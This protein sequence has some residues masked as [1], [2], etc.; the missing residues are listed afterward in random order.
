MIK[1]TALYPNADGVEF[2]YDYYVNKHIPLVNELLSP[3]I[4]GTSV[5]RGIAGAG[6]GGAPYVVMGHMLFDSIEAFQEVMAP[7]AEKLRADV[8][9]FTNGAPVTQISEVG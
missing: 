1:I 8:A 7:A 5:D 2:D 9:N 3:A 6:G 4:K